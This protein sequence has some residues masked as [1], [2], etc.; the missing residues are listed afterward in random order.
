MHF[1]PALAGNNHG[2]PWD[3][4]PHG[5]PMGR[6]AHGPGMGLGQEFGPMGP[7]AL[8]G[9]GNLNETEDQ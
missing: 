5:E 1:C 4:G 6:R 2:C 7:W 9:P 8:N 3:M